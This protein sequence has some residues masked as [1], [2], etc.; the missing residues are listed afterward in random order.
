[1]DRAGVQSRALDCLLPALRDI[2]GSKPW[3]VCTRAA[4]SMTEVVIFMMPC[5]SGFGRCFLGFAELGSVG[6]FAGLP[7]PGK[8]LEPNGSAFSGVADYFQAVG[9]V[10]ST[11]G[12]GPR[13]HDE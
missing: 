3:Q 7:E 9:S 8:R 10:E 1:M 4:V 6:E 11:V 5:C 2:L 13:V 12:G